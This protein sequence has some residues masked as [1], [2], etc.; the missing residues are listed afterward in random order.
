MSAYVAWWRPEVPG[1]SPVTL[2]SECLAIGG[3]VAVVRPWPC[4]TLGGW[5]WHV[6]EHDGKQPTRSV[7]RGWS[8]TKALAQQSA[9]AFAEGATQPLAVEARAS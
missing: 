9:V 2:Q 5:Q 8:A 6:V 7:A 4:S 3:R 1:W